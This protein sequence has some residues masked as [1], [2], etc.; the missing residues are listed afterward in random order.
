ME[1]TELTKKYCFIIESNIEI[2]PKAIEDKWNFKL[3]PENSIKVSEDS[4]NRSVPKKVTDED[5][6][7]TVSEDE[8]INWITD[9]IKSEY[10]KHKTL[11]WARLAAIKIVSNLKI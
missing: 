8:T 1:Q 5:I 2:T 6:E 10:E 4:L 7:T 9:R 11:D 3:R